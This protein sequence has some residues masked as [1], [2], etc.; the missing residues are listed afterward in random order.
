[1]HDPDDPIPLPPVHAEIP[2][3]DALCAAVRHWDLDFRPLTAP[4]DCDCVGRIIQRPWGTANLSYARFVASLD[5]G[6]APP[7]G[8]ITFVVL[9]Q[10]VRRLWWRGRDVD[11]GTV[12]VFP[13]GSELRSFSG[14]DFEVY[15]LSVSEDQV[16][17]VCERFRLDFPATHRRPETFRPEPGLL[18]QCRRQLRRARQTGDARSVAEA[19]E[20]IEALSLHWLRAGQAGSQR[21]QPR[22]FRDLAIAKCLRRIEAPD[23]AELTPAI[24]CEVAPVGERTLQYAFRERFGLSPAAFLKMRRLA[25]VRSRLARAGDPDAAIGEIAASFGFWHTGQF[26]ADYR[27]AFGETPSRTLSR[28]ARGRGGHK[29]RKTIAA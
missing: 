15:T 17:R 3:L 12:L 25:E 9:E 29:P 28:S 1:M 2:D 24:L 27:R 11:A 5:Q 8:N 14:P 21:V 26:A 22:R 23:W 6:G 13:T 19:N 18:D 20:V 10:R 7:A 16:A 4:T